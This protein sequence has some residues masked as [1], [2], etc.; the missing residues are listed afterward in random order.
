MSLMEAVKL[1]LLQIRVQKLKSFFTL[2]GVTIGVMF[3]I[4]VVSIVEGMSRYM[5]EDF[6]GKLMGINTFELRRFPN[7]NIGNT[8][9]ATW[10]AW[11]R[12]PFIR[13]YD[14]HPVVDNLPAGTRWAIEN[15][16]NNVPVEAQYGQQRKLNLHAV[17]GDYFAIKKMNIASGRIFAPQEL[18]TGSL[19]L[20]IGDEVARFFFPNVDPVGH[21]LK[22]GNIRYRIIGVA[23]KQG[24]VFG[25]SL[26]KFVIAP[27][28]SPA[29]RL[30]QRAG[31]VRTL[32]IQGS[33]IDAMNDAMEQVRSTMRARH[34]LRPAQ[35]DDFDMSTSKTAL[36]FW[37]KIKSTMQVAGAALPA[38]GLVVG[39][40]VIMNIMLVAVAE[41]TREI[42]IRKALGARRTDI[43]RQFLME[44]VTLST[45]G[46]AIGVALGIML[47][48]I[49][50]HVSPLPAAVAPWSIIVGVS[51]GAGVGVLAGIYPASR[52]SRLDPIL[53]IRQE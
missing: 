24:S 39:A 29:R 47:A 50:S 22:V 51:V 36:E 44:S 8:T 2:L 30:T 13:D 37:E 11:T 35:P 33:S 32:L 5:E 17:D 6:V 7:I 23:E 28:H 3:L 16:G 34:K 21:E 10:R 15:M 40:M 9:E 49:I 20:I 41:R 38:I 26:D 53:A 48:F 27:L 45:L 46:A 31:V 12:R 43:M 4:T 19:E 18:Q 42:G 52:A 1:A 14:V 25:F